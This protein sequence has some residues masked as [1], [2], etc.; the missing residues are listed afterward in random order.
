MTARLLVR[1]SIKLET[2][3]QYVEELPS[4]TD[5]EFYTPP[6]GE[7]GDLIDFKDVPEQLAVIDRTSSESSSRP[8]S[9]VATSRTTFSH[10][11]RFDLLGDLSDEIDPFTLQPKS[12]S[13]GIQ[14]KPDTECKIDNET[15]RRLPAWDS[16]FWKVYGN[17]LRVNG[18][19]EGV[20]DLGSWPQ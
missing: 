8:S 5:S 18:T 17:K 7:G 6:E 3:G 16:D 2:T 15:G 12:P 14:L 11:T 1:S 13:P 19:M 20:C 4:P 9:G 10:M